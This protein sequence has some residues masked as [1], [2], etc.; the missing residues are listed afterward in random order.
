MDFAVVAGIDDPYLVNN[1][2]IYLSRR[3]YYVLEQMT[4]FGVLAHVIGNNNYIDVVVIGE[5]IRPWGARDLV[6]EMSVRRYD[7]PI[8]VYG[9]V[10]LSDIDYDGDLFVL[11]RDCKPG[12]LNNILDFLED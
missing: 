9:D 6:Q 10:D 3:D 8:I 7:V 12:D 11:G 5:N 2:P 4:S 1:I